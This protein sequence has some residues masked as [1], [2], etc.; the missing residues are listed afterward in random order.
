MIPK[1]K[2]CSLNTFYNVEYALPN[3]KLSSKLSV[4]YTQGGSTPT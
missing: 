4:T 2:D 3:I 1:F